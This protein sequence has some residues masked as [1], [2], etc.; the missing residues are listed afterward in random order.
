M[1]CRLGWGPTAAA[2]YQR[3][4][5]RWQRATRP[6]RV[7]PSNVLSTNSI[8]LESLFFRYVASVLTHML[9][10][11]PRQRLQSFSRVAGS[12]TFVVEH[13]ILCSGTHRQTAVC[14]QTFL[15]V[16][17]GETVS[18]PVSVQCCYN[19]Q[20]TCMYLYGRIS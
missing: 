20:N 6:G 8:E 11:S 4:S 12:G 19:T 2:F 17:C 13:C 9:S 10:L 15:N 16:Y 3:H 5:R 18:R 7:A 14:S 1:V